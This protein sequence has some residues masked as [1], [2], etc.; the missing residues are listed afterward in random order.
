MLR[1]LLACAVAFAPLPAAAQPPAASAPAPV[2]PARAAIAGKV[3]AKVFPKG[4]YRKLMGSSMDKLMASVMDGA[5]AMP[6]GQIAA[7]GG[8]P[9]EDAEKLDKATIGEIL[10][11]YDPH[12]RERAQIG[13]RAM[14]DSMTDL[15]DSFEPRVQA[16]LTRAYARK[17]SAG[18]L[19]ELDAFF[20]TPTGSF[21]AAESMGLYMDPEIVAEMQAMMPE[22]MAKMPD[23]MKA[24]TDATK[25][26]PPA[27][28]PSELKPE[29]RARLASLL[30]VKEKDLR[31]VDI[32]DQMQ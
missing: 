21:Y 5:M 25:H 7:I 22:L 11:I 19:S 14:M 10:T 23:F 4:T 9:T 12:F 27:R 26:L 32:K 17:F 18:Q 31:D 30:G 6:I 15:M 2:D 16:G 28:K 3:V 13:M 29:E 1:T 20:S 8:L 24:M